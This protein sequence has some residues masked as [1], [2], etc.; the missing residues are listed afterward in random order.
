MVCEDC[1]SDESKKRS[2]EIHDIQSSVNFNS[3]RLK[4]DAY[5]DDRNVTFGEIHNLIVYYYLSDQTFQIIENPLGKR[6]FLFYRRRK[7]PKVI[8]TTVKSV[9]SLFFSLKCFD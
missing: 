3:P 6:Q 4:F 5:W 7:L 2:R 1:Q 8:E 9:N